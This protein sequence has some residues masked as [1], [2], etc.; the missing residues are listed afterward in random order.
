MPEIRRVSEACRGNRLQPRTQL[1]ASVRSN[2]M[3]MEPRDDKARV[4]L[5]CG[6][7]KDCEGCGVAASGDEAMSAESASE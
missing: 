7:S 5:A 1:M 2:E 3:V 4:E 6:L